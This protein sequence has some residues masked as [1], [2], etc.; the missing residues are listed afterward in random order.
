MRQTIIPF[1]T[2]EQAFEY[3][4]DTIL[5]N[6]LETNIG[7]KALYNINI[8]ILMPK[9]RYIRTEWRKWSEKYAEREWRWYLSQNRSVEEIKKYAPKWDEMHGGDNIVNS[10]YGWQWGRNN[11]LDKCIEQLK[12]NPDTRQ[13]WISIFDGKEKDQ[14]TYDTPCTMCVGFDIKPYKREKQLDMTVI[15]RSNDLVYGFCNDQYCFS[16]LQELV[17]TELNIPMGNYYHFAHD[18]HIYEK[19]YNLKAKYYEHE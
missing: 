11:Q 12:Q 19:H 3:Y 9:N 15:M 4:Y 5:E 18:L 10:N 16:K 13:A 17:A 7:T 6:G 1:I 14:Y 2:A 8:Q